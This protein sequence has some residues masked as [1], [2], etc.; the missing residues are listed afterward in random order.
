MTRTYRGQGVQSLARGS[1]DRAAPHGSAAPSALPFNAA[2]HVR[3]VNPSRTRAP[4]AQTGASTGAAVLARATS[5][6]DTRT[7]A[8]ERGSRAPR[9]RRGEQRSRGRGHLGHP[10]FDVRERG[11]DHDR[12]RMAVVA[13]DRQVARDLQARGRRRRVDAAGD[14]VREAEDRAGSRLAREQCGRGPGRLLDRVG[15]VHDGRLEPERV[16]DLRDHPL[17]GAVG[18][19]RAARGEHRDAAVAEPVQ[20]LQHHAHAGAVVE[21]HLPHRRARERVAD[22]HDREHLADRLPRGV[23]R[24]ERRDDQPV[25][26]LVGELARQHPLALGLAARVHDHHVQR[27]AG[28][29]RARAPRRSAARS[30]PAASRT[31]R[32]PDRCGRARAP[33]RRR[34]RCSRARRRPGVRA[35]GSP[36]TSALHAA[37]TRWPR[38]RGPSPRRRP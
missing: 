11:R 2:V 7:R 38:E 16:A 15:R 33:A 5:S 12:D 36:G 8:R 26:E 21:Q 17:G 35:P 37:H 34:C 19:R 24:V 28:P 30:G 14:R 31:A 18:R 13:G 29:A 27:R 32:R 20:V 1:R 9:D 22:G 4:S 23:G 25:H 10:P 6:G 3:R